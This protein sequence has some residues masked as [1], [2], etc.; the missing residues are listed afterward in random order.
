MLT[1]IHQRVRLEYARAHI[2][3]IQRQWSRVFFT[4]ESRF[5]LFSNDR[6]IRVWRRRGER[7]DRS[8]VVPVRVFNGGSV[9]IWAGITITQRTNLVVLPPPSMTAVRYT[10]EILRPEVLPF[11][12]KIVNRFILMLVLIPLR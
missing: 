5:C 7:F 11:R 9:K 10:N 6:R 12:E 4:D 8:C 2:D 1:A 3:W